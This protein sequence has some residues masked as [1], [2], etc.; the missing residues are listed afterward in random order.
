ME[1]YFI[2]ATGTEI[3]KTTYICEM[4]RSVR[5]K[6]AGNADNSKDVGG[7]VCA[8]KPVITGF[9]N[10]TAIKSD[11]GRILAALGLAVSK[12]NINK[13]SPYRFKP[14]VSP[15][16]CVKEFS[17]SKQDEFY[18]NMLKFCIEFCQNNGLQN[19]RGQQQEQPRDSKYFK[20]DGGAGGAGDYDYKD[21]R[22]YRGFIGFGGSI[23]FGGFGAVKIIEGAG[24][25]YSPINYNKTYCDLISDLHN[26]V[27]NLKIILL[28]GNYLGTISQ[29]ISAIRNL[30]NENLPLAKVVINDNI[31]NQQMLG[32][33][34]D[35]IKKYFAKN[36]SVLF[37]KLSYLKPNISNIPNIIKQD[38]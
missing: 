4:I 36:N 2:T 37:E 22:D 38:I 33:N 20:G 25:L 31:G 24:G 32:E 10:K 13:I 5:A 6:N 23:G 17:H 28:A 3:G 15:H 27:E 18:N 7:A 34:Y 26:R 1:I 30:M 21:C 14:E 16:L 9:S 29:T 11:S 8:I 35:Y 19:T 12:E